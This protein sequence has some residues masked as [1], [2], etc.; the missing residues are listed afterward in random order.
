M[1]R[2]IWG[3]AGRTYH[4]VGNLVSR[5]IYE[6]KQR[7]LSPWSRSIQK[8]SCPTQLSMKFQL[9][10]KTKMPK[11]KNF[12]CFKTLISCTCSAIIKI[13]TLMSRINF[14]HSWAKIFFYKFWARLSPIQP[15]F[16]HDFHPNFWKLLFLNIFS[17]RYTDDVEKQSI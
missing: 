8:N 14:M 7:K 17:K 4:I 3:F 1:R 15:G 13:L 10:K 11:N 5:L 9:L 2:L 16:S 12:S 6:I